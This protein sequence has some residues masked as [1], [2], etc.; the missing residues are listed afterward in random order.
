MFCKL[1]RSKKVANPEKGSP[2]FV[3]DEGL[4]L[5]ETLSRPAIW[6]C[7]RLNQING[8]LCLT[9]LDESLTIK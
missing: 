9:Q 5:Q 2:F 3:S 7:E 8:S 4:S 6:N 1:A